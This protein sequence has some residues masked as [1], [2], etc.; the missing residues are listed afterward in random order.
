MFDV[1]QV[2]RD[3]QHEGKR[4][5]LTLKDSSRPQKKP[6]VAK[7]HDAILKGVQDIGGFILVLTMNGEAPI[8]G[9]LIARDKFTITVELAN[10]RRLTIYKHAIE[11]FEP[12]QEQ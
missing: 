3:Q 1:D 7:G 11:S 12:I 6:F 10:G 9:K 2:R 8:R 5:T 4:R